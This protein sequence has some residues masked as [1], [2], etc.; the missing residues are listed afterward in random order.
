MLRAQYS[1]NNNRLDGGGFN[2]QPSSKGAL[3]MRAFCS[4]HKK[5]FFAPRLSPVKCENRGHI[6]GE[7]DFNGS[8][9][10]ASHFQ[11]QYCCNCEHFSLVDF[12]D[13]GLQRCPVCTRRTST[14]YL[15]DQCGTVSFESSTPLQTK[16]FTLSAEGIPQ[17][18]CPA[19][20]RP[21]SADLRE[22][23]CDDGEISFVTGLKVCPICHD[24]LDVGPSFPSSVRDYLKRTRAA[25]KF[26]VTFD[27]E[28]ELFVLI[29][30]GEFVAVSNNDESGRTYLLPRS[31]N[32]TTARDFYEL[33]Q[34]Y[35]HCAAP[36]SGEIN[37]SEPA[38]VVETGDG[39]KFEA[40]GILL[41]ISDEPG[42]T[43]VD[44]S[45]HTEAPRVAEKIAK[46]DTTAVTPCKFCETLVEAKYAFC[47]KCGHPRSAK[48]P[49]PGLHPERSRVLVSMDEF[50]NEPHE[51][52]DQKQ[53]LFT[54]PLSWASALPAQRAT[55]SNGS[56]LKLFSIVIGGLLFGFLTLFALMRSNATVPASPANQPPPPATQSTVPTTGA[57]APTAEMKPASPQP[58]S[59]SIEDNE[60]ERLRQ[61]RNVASSSDR[62]KILQ[63]LSETEKKYARD[64][65]FPYERARIVVGLKKN[66]REEAF[67]ALTRAAQKAIHSGKAVEMLQNLNKDKDG[68]FQK[69]SNGNREWAQL[70]RALKSKDVSVLNIEET[71]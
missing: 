66:F 53:S 67:A 33:Y 37:I 39:W 5:S 70:Q 56:V 65:R 30:D 51:P 61:L 57:P 32:L 4:E 24:R 43:P 29:A 25:N 7:L 11:W 18:C 3:T 52:Q 6:L 10:S 48:A 50:E 36:E 41:V 20:L 59:S 26:Y 45:L 71:F 22:H 12:D 13:H 54:R 1:F 14:L 2:R 34:D 60:L 27:Y 9:G 69:L 38:V 21:N 28:T 35:Y 8:R 63:R 19:C 23:V 55:R 31:T 47:W 64:Y 42:K 44:R 46:A 58:P 62:S 49:G 40:P 17:P 15:C 16:N 68:D